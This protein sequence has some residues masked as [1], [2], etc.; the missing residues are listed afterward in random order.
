LPAGL[1]GNGGPFGLPQAPL[2]VFDDPRRYATPITP[3]G[4]FQPIYDSGRLMSPYAWV[5]ASTPGLAYWWRFGAI[6]KFPTTSPYASQ[7]AFPNYAGPTTLGISGTVNQV[8]GLLPGDTDGA[9]QLVASGSG[10]LK[11]LDYWIPSVQGT[12]CF[13]AEVWV[14]LT[15][16]TTGNYSLAGAW[17]GTYGW[18]L[19]VHATDG[20]VHLY[21]GDNHWD[22]GYALQANTVYHL[23]AVY[24]G[25]ADYRS[26][27]YV[28]GVEVANT[29]AFGP[30]SGSI[31]IPDS[32]A[33]NFEVGKYSNTG[34][35]ASFMDGIIDELALYTRML[36]PAEVAQHYTAAFVRV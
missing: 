30:V 29:A 27:L 11:E 18:M 4:T 9:A 19:Y 2:R 16:P 6:E 15:S 32:A 14:K 24:G 35:G 26:H 17:N 13:S 33:I 23:V 8:P 3:T 31:N 25:P 5:I 7:K 1:P 12:E 20:H 34:A 10:N 36:Q 28:N 22:T 21:T